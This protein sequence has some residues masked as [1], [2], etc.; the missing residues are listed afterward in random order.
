MYNCTAAVEQSDSC[1]VVQSN[2]VMGLFANANEIGME[3]AARGA[4]VAQ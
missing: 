3:S 4:V 1:T 2:V